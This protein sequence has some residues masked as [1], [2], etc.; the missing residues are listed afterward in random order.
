MFF[1]LLTH[2]YICFSFLF[3]CSSLSENIHNYCTFNIYTKICLKNFNYWFYLRLLL[4]SLFVPFIIFILIIIIIILSFP[5]IC[6]FS[7]L[8]YQKIITFSF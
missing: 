7:I 1:F 3:L 8:Y 5:L 2:Y 4:Y 6:Y